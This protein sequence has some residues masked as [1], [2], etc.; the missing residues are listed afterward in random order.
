M[1]PSVYVHTAAS[2]KSLSMK[3]F[4]LSIENCC[5]ATLKFTNGYTIMLTVSFDAHL[6]YT[7]VIHIALAEHIGTGIENIATK[8]REL[9]FHITNL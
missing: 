9:V 3:E 2:G 7:E 5:S 8:R 6:L 1:S 4:C